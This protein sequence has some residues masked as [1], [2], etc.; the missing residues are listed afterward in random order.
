MPGFF[1]TLNAP[2]YDGENDGAYGYR[3]GDKYVLTAGHVFFDWNFDNSSP[4]ID[5]IVFG[6]AEGNFFSI[7]EDIAHNF[8]PK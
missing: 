6:S 3:I 1:V 4:T 8:S 7:T 2:D 5:D